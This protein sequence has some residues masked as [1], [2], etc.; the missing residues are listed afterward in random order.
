MLILLETLYNKNHEEVQK[1][2]KIPEMIYKP[3]SDFSE[4]NLT[5]HI[6]EFDNYLFGYD[7][8]SLLKLQLQINEF[9]QKFAK[10][11]LENKLRPE[12]LEVED[13]FKRMSEVT[14]QLDI[15]SVTAKSKFNSIRSEVMKKFDPKEIVKKRKEK[16]KKLLW[17]KHTSQTIVIFLDLREHWIALVCHRFNRKVEFILLDSENNKLLFLKDKNIENLIAAKIIQHNWTNSKTRRMKQMIYDY[18]S[19]LGLIMDCFT[20]HLHLLDHMLYEILY[21]KLPMIRKHP[22]TRRYFQVMKRRKHKSPA[23]FETNMGVAHTRK[24]S[25]SSSE[26]DTYLQSEIKSKNKT[27]V[28]QF[29]IKGYKEFEG[30]EKNQNPAQVIYGN[31]EYFETKEEIEY[32]LREMNHYLKKFR[33]VYQGLSANGRTNFHKLERDLHIFNMIFE[34]RSETRLEE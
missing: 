1:M 3:L 24:K 9:R 26:S 30:F 5:L 17:G 19:A 22:K 32:N 31:S 14:T 34:V 21:K 18:Q 8:D 15:S 27:H 2:I 25:G 29:H 6:L 13:E 23:L 28:L 20:G 10:I 12:D 7:F 4:D 16:R 33:T 11:L